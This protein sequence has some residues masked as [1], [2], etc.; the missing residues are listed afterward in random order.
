M[1]RM[2]HIVIGCETLDDGI[3]LFASHLGHAPDPGGAHVLMGTH[4]RLLSLGPGLYLELIAVDPDAPAPGRARWYALDA[5]SGPPRVVGWVAR[6]TAFVAPKGTTIVTMQRGDLK[7]Q[8]SLPDNA[9]MPG[10]GIY[11]LMVRWLDGGH[12]TRTLTDHGYRLKRLLLQS[13]GGGGRPIGDPRIV[14][15]YGPTE[16][17]IMIATPDGREVWI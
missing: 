13:P 10:E 16:M 3:E 5:F 4:N 14:T 9:Q 12:P 8:F 1:R 17:R 15:H 6:D 2:D 7:S 11:P